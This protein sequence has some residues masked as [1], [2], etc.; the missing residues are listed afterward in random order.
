[1]LKLDL[2]TYDVKLPS[3]GETVK[4]RPFTV[5]E[6]KLL[7][8]ALESD[9]EKEII[10]TTKQVVNN[11]IVSD[12]L[13]LDKLP[14]FDV[15]YL[16]IA[17]RAK[18][19]G[20]SVDVKF[21]CEAVYDGT[22]CGAIFPIKIDI[23]NVLIKKDE[24][25]KMEISVPP[26]Y[27]LKMKYP[28]YTTVKSILDDDSILNKKITLIAG[29]LAYIVDGE[30]MHKVSEMPKEEVTQFIESLTHD[31]FSKLEYFVDHYPTFVVTA[32][33]TCPQCGYE[34]HIEYKDFTRFFV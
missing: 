32:D 2:P 25:A 33:A 17:L 7:L 26:K 10:S 28:S 9:D 4:I 29:S 20:E 16:F 12:P 24:N 27:T 14:F 8:M 11:C 21:R 23:S 19:V 31:Q 30:Q 22:R 13:E 1:M 5:K 18:S 3:S 15:D 34:H 6:E